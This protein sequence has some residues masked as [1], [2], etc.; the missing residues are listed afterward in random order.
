MPHTCFRPHPPFPLFPYPQFSRGFASIAGKALSPKDAV[1]VSAVRTP[2]GAFKG[3]L[4]SVSA[5]QLG[6]AAVKAALEKGGVKPTDVDEVILGNVVGAGLGQAPARQVQ[7]GAGIPTSAEALT[8]NKVCAS[9]MKTITLAAQNIAL[10]LSVPFPCLFIRP[11][12]YFS[13]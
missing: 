8:V 11:F 1:I 7:I 6:V 9:G 12:M 10:G 3:A 5:T 2:I 13:F 4:A